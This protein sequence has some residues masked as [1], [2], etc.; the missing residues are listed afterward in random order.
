MPDLKLKTA[1]KKAK[2][3]KPEGKKR[4]F[5]VLVP[6]STSEGKLVVSRR[7]P[8]P[9]QVSQAKASLDALAS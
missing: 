5:F 8:T 9:K 6:K 2:N 3:L 4:M 7:K 1:L